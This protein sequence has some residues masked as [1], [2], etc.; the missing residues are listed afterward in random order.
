MY[1][2]IYIY[3]YV[4]FSFRGGD[5]GARGKGRSRVP[6][7]SARGTPIRAPKSGHKSEIKLE[8]ATGNPLEMSSENTLEK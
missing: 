7:G 1:T 8:N 6:D 5:F 4:W 3:I 2:Y